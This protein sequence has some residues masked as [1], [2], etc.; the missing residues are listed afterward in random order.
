VKDPG[1]KVWLVFVLA[2]IAGA[3]L[4]FVYEWFP[5]PLTAVISPVNESL[6]EHGKLLFWPLTVSAFCLCGGEMRALSPRLLAAVIA[7]LAVV[8]A[9]YVYHVPLRGEALAVD[10]ILYAAAMALG[11][12]LAG[13]LGRFAGTPGWRKLSTALACVMAVLFIWFTYAPPDA[14]IFAEL[15]GGIRTFLTIPV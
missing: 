10:L 3:V 7:S 4:H 1:K 5:N 9:G 15:D 6:W 11:F 2:L 8:G 14:V 12:W 13:P